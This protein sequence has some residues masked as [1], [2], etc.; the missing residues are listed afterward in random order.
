MSKKMKNIWQKH[1][2]FIVHKPVKTVKLNQ[3]GCKSEL[4]KLGGEEY[5]GGCES[6]AEFRFKL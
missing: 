6:L 4:R 2:G 3:G 1:R 5:L